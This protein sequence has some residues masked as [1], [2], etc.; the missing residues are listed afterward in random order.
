MLWS[1]SPM[2]S[3]WNFTVS[4]PMVKSLIHFELIL[5]YGVLSY[6]WI[7]NIPST[8]VKETT[9]SSLNIFWHP[10]QRSVDSICLDL[11]HCSVCMFYANTYSFDYYSFAI[12]FEIRKCDVSSSVIWFEIK[13]CDVSSLLLLSQDWCGY[14]W[15]FVISWIIELFCLFLQKMAL[16]F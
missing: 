2:F 8:F 16:R 6:M 13:N 9:L 15:F 12:E 7:S 4:G 3:S 5:V 14:S 10:C 11:F 1:F